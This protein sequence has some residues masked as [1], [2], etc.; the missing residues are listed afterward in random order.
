MGD[1]GA[2]LHCKIFIAAL[3]QKINSRN[4]FMSVMRHDRTADP[5]LKAE[6]VLL[7]IV[8]CE[9][10]AVCMT[11]VADCLGIAFLKALCYGSPV[12]EAGLPAAFLCEEKQRECVKD[13]L[14][15][16]FLIVLLHAIRPGH[17]APFRREGC[18]PVCDT[19]LVSEYSG[20]AVNA[21]Q[22]RF[23]VFVCQL[24]EALHCLWIEVV[25][26]CAAVEPY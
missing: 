16:N 22:Q 5:G 20:H 10:I 3:T 26:R 7:K 17:P 14:S 9:L 1:A 8:P 2:L 12:I 21:L 6:F 11:P 24:Y 15:S 18:M 13:I 23:V 25:R 19:R 4:I